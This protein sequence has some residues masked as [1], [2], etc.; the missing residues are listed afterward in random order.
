MFK[1]EVN[2]ASAVEMFEFLKGHAQYK[3]NIANNVKLYNLELEGSEST[4]LTLLNYREYDYTDM[5][6]KD[7][8]KIY[9]GYSVRFTGRCAGHLV[10]QCDD[11]R[12]NILP[13][14]VLDCENEQD[15][16]EYIKENGIM[17]TMQELEEA[18]EIVQ[19]F[20]ALTDNMRDYVN[21]LSN[22]NIQSYILDDVVYNFNEEYEND[23][24]MFN[25]DALEFN[26]EYNAIDVTNIINIKCLFECLT[27]AI[28][29]ISEYGYCLE[30]FKKDGK[31]FITF[32]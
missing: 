15:L 19:S 12:C 29:F 26:E 17:Y 18:T 9:K 5:L 20:D 3:N 25:I 11:Y 21:D 32:K 4:A 13:D 6:I 30:E 28:A 24:T 7:W 1:K 31:A 22:C 27:K 8:K 14:C 23:L 10:L 2:T 16:Q